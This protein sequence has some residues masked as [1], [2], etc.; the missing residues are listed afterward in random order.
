MVE[1]DNLYKG[2]LHL[3]TERDNSLPKNLEGK[4]GIGDSQLAMEVS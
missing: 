3:N 4:G 1:I 2:T